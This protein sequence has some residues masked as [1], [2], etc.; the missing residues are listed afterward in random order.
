LKVKKGIFDSA[1]GIPE[2]L[3]AKIIAV[4]PNTPLRIVNSDGRIVIYFSLCL[5]TRRNKLL[6]AAS[7]FDLD[8]FLNSNI[9][10]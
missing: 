1:E 9:K 2:P 3:P 4:K 8:I 6:F 5:R 7:V 10:N